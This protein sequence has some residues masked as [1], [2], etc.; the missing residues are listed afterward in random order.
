MNLPTDNSIP[1][2]EDFKF[3]NSGSLLVFEASSYQAWADNYLPQVSSLSPFTGFDLSQ[4]KDFI[5]IGDCVLLRRLF[6]THYLQTHSSF[7]GLFSSPL[8]E[9]IKRRATLKL[10][11]GSKLAQVAFSEAV[12]IPVLAKKNNLK[13]VWMSLTPMEVAT[14]RSGIHRANGNVLIAGMGLG[15]MTRRILQRKQVKSVTVVEIN[16]DILQFFGSPLKSEFSQLDLVNQNVWNF[17]ENSSHSFDSYIFDIWGKYGEA[18]D[19]DRFQH[20]KNWAR[21]ENKRIWGW[22]DVANTPSSF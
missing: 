4:D 16:P 20:L 6:E 1:F 2:S 17:L 5:Q 15:W 12:C 11:Q 22:G 7:G 3:P 13:D 8:K 9:P 10:F 18:S 21:K 14:C 19:D